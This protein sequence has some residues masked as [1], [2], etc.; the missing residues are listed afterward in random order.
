MKTE[1]DMDGVAAK[2]VDALVLADDLG[3]ARLFSSG[4]HGCDDGVGE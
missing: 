4:R 3:S 1:E 2:R